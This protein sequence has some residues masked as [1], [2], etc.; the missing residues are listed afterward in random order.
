TISRFSSA[1]NF[2]LPIVKHSCRSD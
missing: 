1:V 2:V